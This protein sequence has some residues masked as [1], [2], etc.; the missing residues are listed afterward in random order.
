MH[1]QSWDTFWSMGGNAWFV[2]GSYGVTA[3]L[4]L[5]ELVLLYTGTRASRQRLLRWFKA[6]HTG[7]A[8]AACPQA[9]ASNDTKQE[10]T[11]RS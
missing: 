10:P 6:G 9:P 4:M 2:W 3:A 1:W 5:L 8:T 11:G 7:E